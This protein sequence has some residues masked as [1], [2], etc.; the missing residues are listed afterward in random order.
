VVDT[1]AAAD[2]VH[3]IRFHKVLFDN[4]HPAA[5][6]LGRAGRRAGLQV[7]AIGP[8]LTNLWREL[9]LQWRREPVALAGMTSEAAAVYLQHLAQDAGLRLVLRASHT[10]LADGGVRHHLAGPRT[11]L[12]QAAWLAA[13]ERWPQGALALLRGCRAELATKERRTFVSRSG[14]AFGPGRLV[15]WAVSPVTRHPHGQYV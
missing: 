1:S 9:S 5:A 4:D 11:T 3:P 2:A 14:G 15:T 8:D 6:A 10:P 13:G 12:D 7:Q